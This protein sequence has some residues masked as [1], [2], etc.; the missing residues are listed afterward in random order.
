M[1]RGIVRWSLALVLAGT[2]L[3]PA[4]FAAED[5]Q[6]AFPTLLI[7]GEVVSVDTTDPAAT[8]LKVKDR[9]GFETPIHLTPETTITQGAQTLTVANLSPGMS[10]EVMFN[11]DTDTAKRHAVNVKVIGPLYKSTIPESPEDLPFLKPGIFI[12]QDTGPNPG[13]GETRLLYKT[14]PDGKQVIIRTS[15]DFSAFIAGIPTA[16]EALRLVRFFDDRN[17]TASC[18]SYG[19]FQDVQ[20]AE[21]QA[22]MGV[23]SI[24]QDVLRRHSVTPPEVSEIQL[25]NGR[26]GFLI[27]RYVF[28]SDQLAQLWKVRETGIR[29]VTEIGRITETVDTAGNYQFELERIPVE[30]FEVDFHPIIGCD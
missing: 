8:L 6:K 12:W 24:P 5:P 7:K 3:V 25:S 2:L 9:Y 22:D 27:K 26:K 4:L 20:F 17:F 14:L 23:L 30:G 1:E 11:F 10:V 19:Y 15:K 16:E 29:T 13:H 18:F 28:L 21:L